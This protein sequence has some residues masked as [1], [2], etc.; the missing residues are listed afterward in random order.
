MVMNEMKLIKIQK[1]HYAVAGVIEALLLVALFSIVLS[2]I[3]LVY[4]PDIMEQR[5]VEHMDEVE[6]QFSY[7]KSVIDLQSSMKENV[8][9]STPITLGSRELPYFVTARAFGQLEIVDGG[10]SKIDTDFA[11]NIPLT[12]IKYEAV[13]SYFLDQELILEGGGLIIKQDDGESMRIEPPI[14]YENLTG[15][16]RIFWTLPDFESVAGK[17]STSGFKGCYI[18]SNYSSNTTYFGWTTYIKIYSDYLDAWN[19][20]L[21]NLFE[22]PIINGYIIIQKNS[23]VNPTYVEI[24]PGTKGI[25]L[26]MTVCK[27]LT[28]IGPGIVI[29]I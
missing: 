4:I 10:N 20:S 24:I 27:I 13:N 28:Q 8:P 22:E 1:T 6:N 5:E 29:Q 16:M 2:T 7:L 23:P 21:N 18:R 9:I 11:T 12:L 26:E 19:N 3:Q 14:S 15:T 17:N 25:F